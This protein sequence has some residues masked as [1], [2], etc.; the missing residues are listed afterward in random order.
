MKKLMLALLVCILILSG[1]KKEEKYTDEDAIMELVKNSQFFNQ[2]VPVGE[3]SAYIMRDS[4]V[5]VFWGREIKNFPSP[6][7]DIYIIGD[8]AFVDYTGYDEGILHIWAWNADSNK[9]K[10]YKKD[11]A[12]VS[13]IKG[14][15]KR[16]GDVNDPYRGWELWSITGIH[17]FSRDIQPDFKIDSIKVTLGNKVFILKDPLIF[18]KLSEV[19][20]VHKND[21]VGITVYVNVPVNHPYFHIIGPE[22]KHYRLKMNEVSPGIYE[23]IVVDSSDIKGYH[24]A[25]VDIL[26]D[27]TLGKSDGIYKTELWFYLYYKK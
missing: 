23:K 11:F 27:E 4:I 20:T 19:D 8:S 7:V 25:V 9:I 1:C 16:T 18:Q 2:R 14:I 10:Y 12:D 26:A 21:I 6:V 24:W 15:F 17:T 22:N 13:Y 3:D 5:P